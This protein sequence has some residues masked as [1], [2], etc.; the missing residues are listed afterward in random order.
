MYP[1]SNASI[2]RILHASVILMLG[3]HMIVREKGERSGARP[4]VSYKLRDKHAI[5][6]RRWNI[7]THERE[8]CNVEIEIISFVVDGSVNLPSLPIDRSKYR[9]EQWCSL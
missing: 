2:L 6:R 8:V 9:L 5:G 4:G 3:L 1:S 7:T